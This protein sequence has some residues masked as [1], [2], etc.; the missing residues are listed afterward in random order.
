MTLLMNNTSPLVPCFD[1][2]SIAQLDYICFSYSPLTSLEW[3]ACIWNYVS[4]A[5]ALHFCRYGIEVFICTCIIES[6][7]LTDLN[8]SLQCSYRH[9]DEWRWCHGLFFFQKHLM[10]FVLNLSISLPSSCPILL[11]IRLSATS[12]TIASIFPSSALFFLRFL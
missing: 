7:A 4:P 5:C 1:Y 11:F 6:D 12:P 10:K 9:R 3:S 8:Q 2:H